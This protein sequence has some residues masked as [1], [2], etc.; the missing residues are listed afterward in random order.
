LHLH[1]DIASS[2]QPTLYNSS[3]S[4][5]LIQIP[6]VKSPLDTTP[7]LSL[8]LPQHCN[9]HLFA[10]TTTP[11]PL[12]SRFILQLATRP[13][14]KPSFKYKY[15]FLPITSVIQTLW[16]TTCDTTISVAD[17]LGDSLGVLA[18]NADP[19][20]ILFR[21]K[22]LIV[23]TNSQVRNK[24]TQKTEFLLSSDSDRSSLLK[25]RWRWVEFF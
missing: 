24:Y 2:H 5:P 11:L 15:H 6:S 10:T 14:L 18:R 25:K 12:P 17:F 1:L 19:C 22:Q 7:L 3:L 13:Q 23:S 4:N 16:N 9:D 20:R 8:P 21:N